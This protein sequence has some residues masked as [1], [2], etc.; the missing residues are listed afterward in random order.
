[1][2]IWRKENKYKFIKGKWDRRERC[3]HIAPSDGIIRLSWWELDWG[4]GHRYWSWSSFESTVDQASMESIHLL[5][6][7]L[8]F[9]WPFR[10][11][12]LDTHGL[13]DLLLI[14]HRFCPEVIPCRTW[15][16]KSSLGIKFYHK[17]KNIKSI[18]IFLFL[19]LLFPFFHLS[20]K[21]EKKTRMLTSAD[22]R[23]AQYLNIG[24]ELWASRNVDSLVRKQSFGA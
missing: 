6:V 16:I 19:S 21:V 24:E 9:P 11:G 4:W 15:I 5:H 8:F 7:F 17:Q 1:M 14:H 22:L 18:L 20:C 2:R 23:R 13:F 12:H 3:H 10:S